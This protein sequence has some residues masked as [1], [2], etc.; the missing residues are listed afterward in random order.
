MARILV[1]DDDELYRVMGEFA[2][3]A[4]GHEVFSAID[5]VEGL[6]TLEEETFDLVITDIVMPNQEGIETI[7]KVQRL[8]PVP[9]LIAV[10][11]GGRHGNCEAYLRMA[12]AFGVDG[13]LPKPFRPQSLV[14][15][16]NEV[17]PAVSDP[18]LDIVAMSSGA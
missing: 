13:V 11:G 15:L 16:V 5:G 17:M 1:I 18:T 14:Q 12:R 7:L 4:E 2:L 3:R 6:R 10:S 8:S 9:K